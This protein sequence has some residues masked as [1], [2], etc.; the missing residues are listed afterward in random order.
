MYVCEILT[1]KYYT[2][3]TH[4][5]LSSCYRLANEWSVSRPDQSLCFASLM[6]EVSLIMIMR[7]HYHAKR[8]KK[9]IE[10]KGKQRERVAHVQYTQ[11]V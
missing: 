1:R 10:R 3:I 2:H 8:K 7:I 5:S 6:E 9:E 4:T 11:R